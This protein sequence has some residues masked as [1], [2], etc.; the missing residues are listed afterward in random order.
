MAEIPSTIPTQITAGTTVKFRRSFSDY[1]TS[2]SWVY[3]FYLAG[4]KVLNKVATVAN[5]EFNVTLAATDTTTLTPGGYK[6]SEVVSKSGE[7]VSVGSGV[8]EV[9][10]NLI[11]ATAGSLQSLEEKDLAAIETYLTGHAPTDV[12]SYTI[13]GRSLERIP[14]EELY[15]LRGKLQAKVWR[16]KNPGLLFGVVEVELGGTLA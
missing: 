14:R 3:T 7:I 5:G 11:T 13:N 4:A 12:K 6:Y 2:D 15:R 16:Q 10:P 1:P 8:L 9:L